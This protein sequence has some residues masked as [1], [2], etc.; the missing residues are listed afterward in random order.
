MTR[1]VA[2]VTGASS[3]IG[4]AVAKRLASAGYR[5]WGTAR[6]PADPPGAV[7]TLA[8]DVRSDES[9][10]A[11]IAA[12]L[13]EEGRLDAVI[14]NAGITATGAIEET[15]AAEALAVLDTNLLGAHR[16]TRACLPHLRASRGHV[17]FVGSIAG[18]LPKPF[19]AFYAASK[20]AL[21][22]YAESLRFEVEP[23]G[24]RVA[25]L[26]PGFVQTGL[27][28]RADGVAERLPEY[29]ARRQRAER[30]LGDDVRGGVHVAAVAAE[31]AR[32]LREPSPPLRTL[33]GRDAFVLHALRALL[34]RRAFAAGLRRR[35]DGRLRTN[36]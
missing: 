4:A 1:S 32:L 33:V 15:S 12:L 34:P 6:R 11:C 2:L 24:V 36:P 19:E 14:N 13:R 10:E 35:F 5:V 16:V 17:I 23:F 21:R 26:E 7:P 25:L 30:G 3:G 28:T 8:L 27:A 22:A 31:V 18:F 9:V 29:A 20:H